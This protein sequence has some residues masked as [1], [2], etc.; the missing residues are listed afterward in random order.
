MYQ[1]VS[2][3]LNRLT[4]NTVSNV[5]IAAAVFWLPIIIF[6]GLANEVYEKELLPFDVAILTKLHSHATPLLDTIVKILTQLGGALFIV[7]IVLLL[8]ALFYRRKDFQSARLLVFIAGGAGVIN[9]FL[10]LF[11]QRDRPSLW[12]AL[13]LEHSYSFPSGHAMA[14]SAFAFSMMLIF[15]HSKWRWLVVAL[16]SIYV[17]LVGVSRVY[18]GVH[19]PSDILAG[20]CISLFWAI[21]A[22]K[23]VK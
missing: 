10:K 16:G 4:P 17:L 5:W 13:V 21:V 7:A 19:Y 22:F 2:R 6:I 15:R 3:V 14:S 9:F 11:F 20:W 8:A 1:K 23:V 18:L 12:D